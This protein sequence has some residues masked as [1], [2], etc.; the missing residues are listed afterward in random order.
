MTGSN[1]LGSIAGFLLAID[2]MGIVMSHTAAWMDGIWPQAVG[3]L[4]ALLLL[5]RIRTRRTVAQA[6]PGGPGG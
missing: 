2:G 4:R 3:G 5:D 6:Q 1:L